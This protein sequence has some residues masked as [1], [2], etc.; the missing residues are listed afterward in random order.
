MWIWLQTVE[1]QLLRH[2]HAVYEAMPP[3]TR[4]TFTLGGRE[5]EEVFL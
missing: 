5:A 3:D 2:R 1:L 4:A